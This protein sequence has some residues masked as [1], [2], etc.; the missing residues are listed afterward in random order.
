MLEGIEVVELSEIDLDFAME[1]M[2][3]QGA[4]RSL[5]TTTTELASPEELAALELF[6]GLGDKDLAVLAARCQSIQAVPGHVLLAP[7]RL[8]TKVFFVV[9]GQLRLYAPT[10]DKRP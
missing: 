3:Q 5:E 6:R 9:E 8:N 10:N 2:F 4:P 1:E 7:G